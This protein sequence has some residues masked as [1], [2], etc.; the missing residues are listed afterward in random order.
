M[1][2]TGDERIDRLIDWC[3]VF[4]SITEEELKKSSKKVLSN[5]SAS[6]LVSEVKRLSGEDEIMIEFDR[7]SKRDLELKSEYDEMVLKLHQEYDE[8][9]KKLHQQE[10]QL[11]EKL[12]DKDIQINNKQIE[13]AKNLLKLNISIEDISISTGLT[14]EEIKSINT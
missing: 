11:K 10:E 1:S 8:K 6:K 9:Y 13:I 2:Y 3:K 4:T 7:N 14:I 12:K 5:K